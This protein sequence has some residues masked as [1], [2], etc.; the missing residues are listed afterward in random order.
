MLSEKFLMRM[1][2]PGMLMLGLGMAAGHAAAQE[3]PS[4]PIRLVTAPAGGSNDL[5]ARI[6]AQ[7]IT[8]PIGQPV[9]V[10]NRPSILSKEIAVRAQP[11]GY[12]L[13]VVG[14]LLWTGPL[15]EHK[16]YDPLTEFSPVTLVS[17]R[18]LTLVAHA[19]LPVSSVKDL[20]ALAK[21]RPGEINVARASLGAIDHLAAE[22]LKSSTG[23]NIAVIPYTGSGPA[24]I[25]LVGGQV[26]LYFSPGIGLVQPH[27]KSG[28]L[29]ALAVTSAQRSALT[30]DLPTISSTV[31][32]FEVS[33]GSGIYAP[34][35]T[36]ATVIN[37]LN[38]EIVRYAKSPDGIEKFTLK[39]D[40]VVGTS[41]QELVAIIK[42]EITKYAKLIKDAGIRAE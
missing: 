11:D 38:R 25:A 8:G 30:P 27:I 32:G 12:T 34:A 2:A 20:I 14:S 29:K 4:R 15:V 36:P 26:N 9:I 35:K 31:P 40:D 1:V 42:A 17:T 23:I 24:V 10:E 41:P 7:G 16:R 33:A 37:K 6:I 39:G 5:A 13:Y 3:F 19:S 18:P 28:K 22:L 21:S